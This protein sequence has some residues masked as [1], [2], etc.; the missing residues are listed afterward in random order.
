[1]TREVNAD[2]QEIFGEMQEDL[3]RNRSISVATGTLRI[4]IPQENPCSC[5][6]SSASFSSS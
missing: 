1:M 4:R 2:T 5:G 6:A 3:A